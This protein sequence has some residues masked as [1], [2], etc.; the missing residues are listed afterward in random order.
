M[1]FFP[2]QKILKACPPGQN[3]THCP[4]QKFL[5]S[6]ASNLS[7]LKNLDVCEKIASKNGTRVKADLCVFSRMHKEIYI[8]IYNGSQK[9]ILYHH[10]V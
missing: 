2:T 1:F 8:Y 6:T 3:L 5:F 4:V 7:I 10:P 9:D